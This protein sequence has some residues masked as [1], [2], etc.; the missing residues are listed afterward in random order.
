MNALRFTTEWEDPKRAK[1]PELRATWASLRIDVVA[2]GK[3]RTI[4]RYFDADYNT[5]RHQ[6]FAPIYPVAEWIAY[7][8][9]ALLYGTE[10]TEERHQ[11]LRFAAEG[12]AFPHVRFVSEG[13]ALR[14]CWFPYEHSHGH[15]EFL[16]SGE[17]MLPRAIAEAEFSGLLHRVISRLEEHG[18][19]DTPLQKEWAA[20]HALDGDE[21]DFCAAAA[22]L[23][24]DPFDMPEEMEEQILA[25]GNLLSTE[26]LEEFFPAA[27]I[28]SLQEEAEK[29]AAAAKEL[30]ARRP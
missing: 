10:R 17:M 2:Q 28:D 16:G 7:H 25:A 8:W 4:T 23:G 20:L 30:E 11:D 5:V 27:S 21:R 19:Q 12:F 15:V 26:V 29:L 14:V 18:I 3:P 9:F 1:G 6:I 24:L 13:E 22:K